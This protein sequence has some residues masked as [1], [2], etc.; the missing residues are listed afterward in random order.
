[1]TVKE[2]IMELASFSGDT[3]VVTRDYERIEKVYQGTLTH[4]NYP[5]DKPDKSVVILD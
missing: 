4:D 3:E 5:Y 1:M 2:L